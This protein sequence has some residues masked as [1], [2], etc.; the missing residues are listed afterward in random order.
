MTFHFGHH[1][2]DYNREKVTYLSTSETQAL[3]TKI[4]CF[5]KVGEVA[6]ITDLLS[7]E[8]YITFSWCRVFKTHYFHLFSSRKDN[9]F[10][11]SD[12]ITQ[13]K[14]YDEY[15]T[16]NRREVCFAAQNILS[17]PLHFLHYDVPEPQTYKFEYEAGA[18]K[19]LHMAIPCPTSPKLY[20]R[21]G[22]SKNEMELVVICSPIDLY[23]YQVEEIKPVSVS[24]GKTLISHLR[25][26]FFFL[27]L[28]RPKTSVAN[29]GK[30]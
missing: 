30:R 17:I 14:D 9:A 22:N 21:A 20:L 15:E 10:R 4:M 2:V 1:G 3:R 29:Y 28:S 13:Y 18:V 12:F 7:G 16:Q 26:T 19:D 5:T 27:S 24:R 8:R 11:W 25:G 6:E 23:E